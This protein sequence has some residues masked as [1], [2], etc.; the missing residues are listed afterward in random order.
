M[1]I[2]LAL[3]TVLF[4]GAELL[5]QILVEDIMGNTH[6]KLFKITK[7]RCRLMVFLKKLYFSYGSHFVRWSKTLFTIWVEGSK[8][9]IV[10]LF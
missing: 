6:V 9:H 4:D 3:A 2:F 1:L 5:V 7:R 10:K 8:K